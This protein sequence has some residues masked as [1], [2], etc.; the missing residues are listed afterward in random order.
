MHYITTFYD[1]KGT[2]LLFKEI[3]GILPIILEPD[4][5]IMIDEA[6]VRVSHWQYHF[7]PGEG[8]FELRIFLRGK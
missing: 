4:M 7:K 3:D 2:T 1:K 6:E 8:R 5:K